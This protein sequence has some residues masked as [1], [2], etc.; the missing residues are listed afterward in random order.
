M[1]KVVK[2]CNLNLLNWPPMKK[3]LSLIMGNK[4]NFQFPTHIGVEAPC[5]PCT[6]VIVC[7]NKTTL[8]LPVFS[9]KNFML[10]HLNWHTWGATITLRPRLV[11]NNCPDLNSYKYDLKVVLMFTV[12]LLYIYCTFASIA[13]LLIMILFKLSTVHRVE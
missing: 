9:L 13:V 3:F 11:L 6:L 7:C 1:L 12:H 2:S 10:R 4:Y 8:P 5:L